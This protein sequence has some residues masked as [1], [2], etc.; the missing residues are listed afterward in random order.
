LVLPIDLRAPKALPKKGGRRPLV[1][2]RRPRGGRGEEGREFMIYPTIVGIYYISSFKSLSISIG[3]DFSSLVHASRNKIQ[4]GA[5]QVR[6]KLWENIRIFDRDQ[7]T[8]T[9]VTQAYFA[10]HK[11]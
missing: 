1:G 9:T 5:D 11:T 3:S 4:V 7:I 10:L 8:F 6:V 2:K